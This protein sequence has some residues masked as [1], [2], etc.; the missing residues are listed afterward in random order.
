MD[1]FLICVALLQKTDQQL[2]SIRRIKD[3]QDMNT[4]SILF[5]ALLVV[6]AIALTLFNVYVL[7]PLIPIEFM[8]MGISWTFL[9]S[10]LY[11]YIGGLILGKTFL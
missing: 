10:G 6:G 1:I 2:I 7:L 3:S 8:W 4:K 9:S 5:I 11:G